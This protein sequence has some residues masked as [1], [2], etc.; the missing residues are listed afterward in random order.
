[1]FSRD[2]NLTACQTMIKNVLLSEQLTFEGK[3]SIYHAVTH[4]IWDIWNNREIG[5]GHLSNGESTNDS[6]VK[7]KHYAR[8]E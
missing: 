1:M 8:K 6:D 3:R 7:L 2:V 4:S 5:K